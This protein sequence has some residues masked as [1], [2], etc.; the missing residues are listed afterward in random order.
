VTRTLSP[1]G[2]RGALCFGLKEWGR[3][4]KW[5]IDLM[6]CL[7][8][9]RPAPFT[10]VSPPVINACDGPTVRCSTRWSTPGSLGQVRGAELALRCE[11]RC[12]AGYATERCSGTRHGGRRMEQTEG[13]IT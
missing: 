2:I 4:S 7:A 6:S 3:G 9:R 11:V 12:S 1:V 10:T 13:G 5:N 8:G